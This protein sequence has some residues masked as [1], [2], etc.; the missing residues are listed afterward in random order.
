MNPLRR[1]LRDESRARRSTRFPTDHPHWQALLSGALIRSSRKTDA[2]AVQKVRYQ[3]L[4]HVCAL[5]RP[6]AETPANNHAL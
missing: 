6:C 4:A 3:R 2:P 5:N 1:M